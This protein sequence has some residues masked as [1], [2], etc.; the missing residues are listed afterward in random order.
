MKNHPN[1]DMIIDDIKNIDQTGTFAK[2]D[3]DVIIG[4]ATMSRFLYG[5]CENS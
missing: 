3:A 2:G 1:V 4:G 5:G